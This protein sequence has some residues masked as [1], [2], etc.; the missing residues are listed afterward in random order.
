M[1]ESMIRYSRSGFSPNSAKRRF[2]TPFFAHRRKRLNTLSHLPNASGR[3]RHGAPARTNHNTASMNKRLSSPC[4]PLS[5]S[6]P[7]IN[8]SIR[9]HCPSVSSRRIK[10]ASPV[11]ILNHI[12]ESE[13]IP[14]CQQD[15]MH[16]HVTHNRCYASYND[17][18]RSALK[19]LREEVPK[20]WAILCDSVTDQFPRHQ[21][22][23]FSGSQSIGVYNEGRQRL[24]VFEWPWPSIWTAGSDCPNLG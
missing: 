9:R 14:K 16:Q 8:G 23:R 1:V 19:F 4:R 21:P 2:Q 13:G 11:A 10:I 17:F 5:P 24:P 18:C 20:N 3:S 22:R 15:P 12:R 6:L 7:G